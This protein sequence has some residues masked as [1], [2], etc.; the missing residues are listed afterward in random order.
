VLGRNIPQNG[1]LVLSL[2]AYEGMTAAKARKENKLQM[3]FQ[4]KITLF[5][6]K[7]AF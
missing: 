2:E 4:K 1:L 6:F 3:H 7:V 5:S